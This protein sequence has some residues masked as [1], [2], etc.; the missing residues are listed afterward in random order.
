MLSVANKSVMVSVKMTSVVKLNVVMLN[1]VA[2]NLASGV[3]IHNIL[4]FVA[5]EW[6]Q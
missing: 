5:Q 2:P 4:F 3:R 6:V 1:V